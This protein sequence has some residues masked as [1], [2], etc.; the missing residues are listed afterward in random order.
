[1]LV[2]TISAQIIIIPIMLLSFNQISI[3]FWLSNVL[4]APIIAI[5]II[6]GFVVIFISYINIT[7]AKI[8]IIPIIALLKILIIIAKTVSNIPFSNL[9]MIT[10]NISIIII[11]Y[12]ILIVTLYIKRNNKRQYTTE[13][14]IIAKLKLYTKNGFYVMMLIVIITYG[15]KFTNPKLYIHFID[16]GQ[17][18]CTLII[19]KYGK[20]VLI[21]GGG[22]DGTYDVGK[23]VLIPYLLDRGVFDI[24]YAL[25]SH[26]DSDHCK[27]NYICNRKAKC[28][29]CNNIKTKRGFRKL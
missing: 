19:T 6:F 14:K 18:D 7:I 23:N 21:D 3:M 22:S 20:R 28:R 9:I 10:P 5:C 29:K 16:V 4:A 15:I 1:M 26:F 11:Y 27:R 24:D 12:L 2:V 8:L 25:I 17:G 13:K